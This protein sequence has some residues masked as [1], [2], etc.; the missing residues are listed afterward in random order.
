MDAS[1]KCVIKNWQAIKRMVTCRDEAEQ[2]AR[3]VA[4]KALN[5]L[6]GKYRSDFTTGDYSKKPNGEI[7]MYPKVAQMIQIGIEGIGVEGILYG[8]TENR[9]SA[10][11]YSGD[12]LEQKDDGKRTMTKIVEVATTPEGFGYA[13]LED[14]YMFEME[15][16]NPTLDKF[17]DSNLLE[18]YFLTPMNILIQ[19]W[20]VNEKAILKILGT[21]V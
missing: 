21:K 5:A 17:C 2:Y 9:Y 15:L 3:D 8:S 20:K 13:T 6:D 19:W 1:H 14:G 16:P 7:A 18:S 4:R 12:L 10:Y 11:V